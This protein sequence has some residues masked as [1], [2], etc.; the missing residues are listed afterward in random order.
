LT[1]VSGNEYNHVS[2]TGTFREGGIGVSYSKVLAQDS[3]PPH[4][5]KLSKGHS[6]ERAQSPLGECFGEVGGAWAA[7]L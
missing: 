3:P 5:D 1:S 6:E 2:A 7:S 4:T